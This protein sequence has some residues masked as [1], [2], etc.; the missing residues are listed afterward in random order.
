MTGIFGTFR[1][2]FPVETNLACTL[3]DK[4]FGSMAFLCMDGRGKILVDK[5]N[6]SFAESLPEGTREQYEKLR[7]HPFFDRIILFE[8]NEKEGMI[9]AVGVDEFYYVLTSWDPDGVSAWVPQFTDDNMRL[10]QSCIGR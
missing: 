7:L 2:Q 5:K 8:T 1:T 6:K 4:D 10:L 9:L 3:S